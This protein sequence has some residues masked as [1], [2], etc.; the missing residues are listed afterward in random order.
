MKRFIES[1]RQGHATN[2]SSSHSI[3]LID[4][5]SKLFTDKDIQDR[6][7][8]ENFTIRS[9]EEKIKYLAAQ[10]KQAMLE[11]VCPDPNVIAP[12]VASI[13]K[14]SIDDALALEGVDHQSAMAFPFTMESEPNG[15]KA[16]EMKFVKELYEFLCRSDIAILG[17][18]DNEDPH[19]LLDKGTFVD[20]KIPVDTKAFYRA[21]RDP[22]GYWIL[23]CEDTG[24]KIRINFDDKGLTTKVLQSHSIPELVDLKIT[25]FCTFG[26]DYCYQGS[27]TNGNHASYNYLSQ[28]ISCLGDLGV[29]ELA[30]GGGEPTQYSYRSPYGN[31]PNG[32]SSILERAKFYKMSTNFTTRNL[33]IFLETD[34][35]FTAH[36]VGYS[37]D[38]EEQIHKLGTILKQCRIPPDTITIHY[39]PESNYVSYLYNIINACYS[40][41]FNLLLLGWK[42]TKRGA[43]TKIVEKDFLKQF[44]QVLNTV[45]AERKYV[46]ISADT[47]LMKTVGKKL[48]AAKLVSSI[49]YDT[50]DGLFSAYIDAVD[51]K[52]ARSSY[53]LSDAVSIPSSTTLSTDILTA[54]KQLKSSISLT[55]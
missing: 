44:V 6:Y 29:F 43:T 23:F 47:C 50:Q 53:D 5:K 24:T 15:L 28:I 21:R 45:I 34:I 52:L 1:Y 10:L 30:I 37:V 40:E 20:L 35:D 31:L 9:T 36:K 49:Q 32:F 38:T 41:G 51:Q 22:A 19:P 17:G 18:N 27:T 8:W 4:P 55:L 48:T 33:G 11:S 14:I 12:A 46:S 54:Y 13:L 7:G 39:I 2:S 42:D 26:C 25:D 16:I 3:I